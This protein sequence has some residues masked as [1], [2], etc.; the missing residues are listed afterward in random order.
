MLLGSVCEKGRD[1]PQAASGAEGA[2]RKLPGPS[3][4]RRGMTRA[5]QARARQR[6]R[7]SNTAQPPQGGLSTAPVHVSS[8]FFLLS[9]C[10][11]RRGSFFW[12]A[13][14]AASL[15]MTA[16]VAADA[17][18]WPLCPG[19]RDR[20]PGLR[21]PSLTSD[22]IPASLL[23]L[24]ENRKASIACSCAWWGRAGTPSMACQPSN[25]LPGGLT[26][27]APAPSATALIDPGPEG[28]PPT[29]ASGTLEEA[30]RRPPLLGMGWRR[31]DLPT[32]VTAPLPSSA[33]GQLDAAARTR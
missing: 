10:A 1:C 17:R 32:P 27:V 15:R 22:G 21:L 12:R 11:A 31:G 20:V 7:R 25:R 29:P 9:H 6:Q 18:A 5:P 2:A 28:A 19:S 3:P 33:P 24:R 23:S 16:A 8:G 26:P 14:T 13:I 30:A 4:G